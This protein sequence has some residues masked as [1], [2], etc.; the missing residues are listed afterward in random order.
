MIKSEA[1][2]GENGLKIFL[3]EGGRIKRKRDD[4]REGL[5]E[6]NEQEEKRREP[7]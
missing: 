5:E 1:S 6:E 2:D 4:P 7:E 3:R